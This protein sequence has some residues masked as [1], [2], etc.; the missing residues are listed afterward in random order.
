[1]SNAVTN[2]RMAEIRMKVEAGERL[3]FDDGVY[4]NES[5]DLFAIGELANRVRER[6]NGNNTYY[7][8]NTHLNATN[9][10]VYRCIFCAFRADLKSDKGYL[11]SDA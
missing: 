2:G 10:C 4:L 6:W 11:M 5:S 7:N 1:M 9:V 8:V 3:S